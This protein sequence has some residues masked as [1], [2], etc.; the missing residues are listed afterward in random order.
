MEIKWKLKRFE[1]MKHI[2]CFVTKNR[3]YKTNAEVEKLKERDRLKVGGLMIHSV[4]ASQ[5]SALAFIRQFN[6]EKKDSCVHGFIDGMT[7]QVYQCLPWNNRAWHCAGS[8]NSTHISVEICEPATIEYPK[9][10][11]AGTRRYRD[12]TIEKSGTKWRE[13]GETHIGGT[14]E[15]VVRRT[16][17]AAVELFAFLCRLY[18]LDPLDENTFET[19]PP[20]NTTLLLSKTEKKLAETSLNKVLLGKTR[21][22]KTPLD[23]TQI[24]ERIDKILEE[25]DM[26]EKTPRDTLEK[27]LDTN[28]LGE[29]TIGKKNDNKK[30]PVKLGEIPLGKILLG[31]DVVI[32]SHK[33]G[34]TIGIAS[35]HSDPEHLWSRFGL[36][37][38]EFRENVKEAMDYVQFVIQFCETDDEFNEKLKNELKGKGVDTLIVCSGGLQLGDFQE[39]EEVEDWIEYLKENDRIPSPEHDIYITWEMKRG[40]PNWGME[41]CKHIENFAPKWKLQQEWN[42]NISTTEDIKGLVICSIGMSQSLTEK[43][44]QDDDNYVHGRI[45]YKTDKFYQCLPWDY[46]V[47]DG[48]KDKPYIGIGMAEPIFAECI[49]PKPDENFDESP[50]EKQD[51]EGIVKCTYNTAVEL[52]A[53]LCKQYN[54]NPLEKDVIV[55][56][57]NI[58][59]KWDKTTPYNT[60]E[61]LWSEFDLNIQ[62][63][64]DDVKEAMDYVMY[65]VR[66]RINGNIR[67]EHLQTELEKQNDLK[68]MGIDTALINDGGPR[69]GLYKERADAEVILAK[70]KTLGYKDQ[71]TG[72]NMKYDGFVSWELK[73]GAPNWGKKT[74]E[75]ENWTCSDIE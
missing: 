20:L 38:R 32:S 26:S 53:F 5:P 70:L 69:I 71:K 47:I 24:L 34:N 16:Y 67:N 65:T 41:K 54:L 7:G 28:S 42:L 55:T 49:I 27:L 29:I 52:F 4:G 43:F 6:N 50:D 51:I 1:E 59:D 66:V 58:W 48:E 30:T 14:T 75:E 61:Y 2:K 57:D 17:K 12:G 39:K 3:C 74:L 40:A 45:D 46:F 62:K 33:W 15:E 60:P 35:D 21:I 13:T 56:P 25:M 73:S 8:G 36:S 63:F 9:R 19:A 72:N 11:A 18:D 64:K 23:K 37:L 44:R 68:K 10:D 22:N 31:K